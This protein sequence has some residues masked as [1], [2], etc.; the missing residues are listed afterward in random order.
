M[1]RY[2]GREAIYQI[3]EEFRQRCLGQDHSST[4]L[5]WPER[6]IWNI[7]NL[8]T[9]K[10]AFI[11]NP[12]EGSG[13]FYEK[14]EIQLAGESADIHRLAADLI[15][16]YY[17]FP[18]NV[19]S[20]TKLLHLKEV[21]AWKLSEHD[22][23]DYDAVSAA[24]ESG[25]LGSTGQHY[26]TSI[27]A[28]LGYFIDIFIRL[29]QHSGEGLSDLYSESEIRANADDVAEKYPTNATLTRNVLMH[30]LFP[31]QHERTV[32]PGQRH[33]IRG[34]FSS[35]AELPTD[36]D[37]ALLTIRNELAKVHGPSFDFYDE[38]IRHLWDEEA[39]AP[40]HEEIIANPNY[41]VEMTNKAGG[42]VLADGRFTKE[43]ESGNFTFVTGEVLLSPT[44]D[45]GGGDRFHFMREVQPGDIVFHLTDR[46][47]FIGTSRVTRPYE[48]LP[49]VVYGGYNAPSFAVT[50][51]DYQPLQ[52][53]LDR[54]VFFDDKHKIKLLEERGNWK[55]IFY[56]GDT[57]QSGIR[58]YQGAY[59]TPL[60]EAVLSI[61]EEIYRE[62]HGPDSD[63]NPLRDRAIKSVESEPV[64]IDDL[65]E[66][67]L[68]DIPEL[69]ELLELLESKKQLIIEGSPGTGKTFLADA[70]ACFVTGNP[71]IGKTNDRMEI[72]QFHQSYG[73]E[74]FVHGIRPETGPDG[75]LLYVLRDG[76]FKKMSQ[77]AAREPEK[78]FVIVIDEINRGNLSRIFG[79]LMLLLEYRG[80]EIP[81]ANSGPDDDPF[82]IP[83][84]LYLIGTMNSADRSLTQVDLAM[85]RR[86]IFHRLMPISGMD[87]PVLG[88]W[89]SN[90]HF[91]DKNPA[92]D[93]LGNRNVAVFVKLNQRLQAELG[94]DF[95]IGHSY[96][97]EKALINSDLTENFDAYRKLWKYSINPLL[98]EYFFANNNKEELLEQLSYEALFEFTIEEIDAAI[99]QE[100]KK[101]APKSEIIRSLR[102]AHG[103]TLNEARERVNRLLD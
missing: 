76:V 33:M 60:P 92:D 43:V 79:E 5:L 61:L 67:T 73:Y 101:G 37:R 86:F 22:P 20:S 53:P 85:R 34:A 69:S 55:N 38:R 46:R 81:L 65:S 77:Q 44:I 74:D 4:S 48:T 63:F 102:G 36:L 32:S 94:I 3:A 66:H 14:W 83:E 54:E 39:D 28:I 97:M 57:S 12:D 6:R 93:Y 72:V 62:A 99:I 29:K 80:K 90:L 64:T 11:D 56:H 58:L 41:W 10:A 70:L 30:L 9:L 84:N 71:L 89:F 50:L 45:R 13:S 35:I 16:F 96:F 23:P 51:V 91:G 19:N 8:E 26:L 88:R 15:A 98:E 52:P 42:E 49:D 24:F 1:A 21:I 25:G 59:L 95:Q 27:H 47:A 103:M 31:D 18:S 2:K 100:D 40:E 17:L 87:A 78:K 82:K 75:E 68:T 7:Q